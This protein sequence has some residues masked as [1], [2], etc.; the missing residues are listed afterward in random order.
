MNTAERAASASWGPPPSFLESQHLAEA[1]KER[2]P[3]PTQLGHWDPVRALP[4]TWPLASRLQPPPPPPHL[5][6][7]TLTESGA[8]GT[9]RLI[10]S[11][12]S[13]DPPGSTAAKQ[14]PSPPLP[15]PSSPCVPP[16]PGDAPRVGTDA[17][18][19]LCAG[20]P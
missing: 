4:V 5:T 13:P 8:S 9:T 10:P 18:S 20:P 19:G 17:A 16:E 12:V 14:L 3:P 7:K 2:L 6:S 15:P 11:Y 1:I